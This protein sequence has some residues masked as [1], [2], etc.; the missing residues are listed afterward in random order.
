MTPEQEDYARYMS[1]GLSAWCVVKD[2]TYRDDR[3]LLVASYTDNFKIALRWYSQPE[4]V[5]IARRG[6]VMVCRKADGASGRHTE[7]SI[8]LSPDANGNFTVA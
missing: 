3:P 1:I 4:A 8:D 2:R 7:G 6:V 5:C